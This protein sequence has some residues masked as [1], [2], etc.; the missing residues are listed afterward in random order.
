LQALNPEL[1]TYENATKGEFWH[2][3]ANISMGSQLRAV[4]ILVR[5][6]YVLWA[7]R[8]DDRGILARA[9]DAIHWNPPDVEFT[10][11]PKKSPKPV[12]WRTAKT[13]SESGLD[14][15]GTSIPEDANSPPAASLTYEMMW[16]FPDF[17]EMGPAIIMNTRSAVKPAK[18]LLSKIEGRPVDHY[19]QQYIIG[20]TRAKNAE[21][22]FFNYS[23]LSDGYADEKIGMMAKD[24]FL[25]YKDAEFRASDE[26][27]EAEAPPFNSNSTPAESNTKY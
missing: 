17:I 22:D 9:T 4:P 3:V 24:A 6:T 10:V 23:Y 15:F 27:D 14:R 26:H 7:P 8:G 16:L 20:V 5:K 1:D 13:V 21:G 25:A 19:Y 18:D 11:K 12:V 2:T